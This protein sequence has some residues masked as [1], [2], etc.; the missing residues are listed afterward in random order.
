[1][2]VWGCALALGAGAARA[3]DSPFS[4]SVDIGGSRGGQTEIT[5]DEYSHD[6]GSS[7]DAIGLTAGGV[8]AWLTRFEVTEGNQTINEIAVAF[9]TPGCTAPPCGENGRPFGA[10][11]W[12]DPNQDGSPVDGAFLAQTTGLQENVDTDTFQRIAIPQTDLGE[13]GDFFFV[14]VWTRN[15]TRG[16]PGDFPASLDRSNPEPGPIQWVTGGVAAQFDP[17][18]FPTSAGWIQSSQLPANLRG[19]WLVRAGTGEG[20]D[21][22]S[23]VV[24]KT[25]KGKKGCNACPRKDD[26]FDTGIECDEN[27]PCPKKFTGKKVDCPDGGAGF[28]KKIL[29]RKKSGACG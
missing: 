21:T 12:S 23:F 2:W 20:G 7:E 24:K 9:G 26:L 19:L 22:C 11:I 17:D 5:A 3:E 1:M 6:D 27:N 8:I 25:A 29:G 4:T 18:E 16:N 28:C 10:G 13:V 15:E 14:V